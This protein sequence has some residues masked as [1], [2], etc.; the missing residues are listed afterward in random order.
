MAARAGPAFARLPAGK[1]GMAAGERDKIARGKAASDL[2]GRVQ[3]IGLAGTQG[4]IMIARRNLLVAFWI[5]PALA[6]V[7]AM[8]ADPS[9][10]AFVEAIYAPY[11]AKDGKG[12]SLDS[13]A[14]LKRYFEPR[15]AALIIKDRNDAAGELP[16]LD[17]DPFIAAQDWDISAVNVAVRDTGAWKASATVSFKNLGKPT[18]VILEL[19]KLKNGWRIADINWGRKQTLRGL[20]SKK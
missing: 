4:R 8:A 5:V 9:A 15:L 18:T 6:C 3:R 17:M 1:R 16:T 10:T 2:T 7:G 12:P 11:Q 20:F 13:D 19:V 14:A